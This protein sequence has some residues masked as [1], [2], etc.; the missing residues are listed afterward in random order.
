M[1]ENAPRSE[2]GSGSGTATPAELATVRRDALIQDALEAG[3]TRK[4]ID[5]ALDLPR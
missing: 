5:Q 4:Q 1:A 3:A 2:L